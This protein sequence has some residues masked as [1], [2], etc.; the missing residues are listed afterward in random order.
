MNTNGFD[1]RGTSDVTV[2]I[3]FAEALA[4]PEVIWSLQSVGYNVIAFHRRGRRSAV[5]RLRN[6]RVAAITAPEEDARRAADELRDLVSQ[7]DATAVMAVD[8]SSVWLTDTV[9]DS[10]GVPIVGAT[11]DA[12]Q[13]ALDKR[14]QVERARA[15]GFLVPHS[16]QC[17]SIEDAL[18]TVTC[19]CVAKPALAVRLSSG[20][21]VKG[22]ARACASVQELRA[23]FEELKPFGPLLVQE[24]IS[25]SGAGVFGLADENGVG[26][27]SAHRRLRMMNPGGSGASACV[28]V[29]PNPETQAAA[30][31][32]VRS[33]GWRGMFMVELLRDKAG[34]EW[35]IELNG[36]PWGSMALARHAGFE[37]PAWAV[38]SSLGHSGYAPPMSGA[39][40]IVCRH[41]GR[42]LLHLMFV[43]RGP[44]SAAESEFWPRRVETLRAVL[45]FH[46]ADRWYNWNRNN[47]PFFFEDTLRTVGGALVRSNRH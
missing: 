32:L 22:P 44:R 8:D 27:W 13:L 45:R 19:P 26:C 20:R 9:S 41:L 15:A 36:R 2:V 23:A 35:F 38:Q 12:A 34:R 16:V 43:L 11:G 46:R 14:L 7:S 40:Q 42:E 6:V 17:N 25:G 3:G 18:P 1:V 31:R 21:L 47:V 24:R 39:R 29:S 33:V 5:S 37:Y 28:S 4:A 30:E 10:L